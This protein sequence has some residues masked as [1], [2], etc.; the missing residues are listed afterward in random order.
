MG[1]TCLLKAE[2]AQ[3]EIPHLEFVI[4]SERNR[5]IDS[6]YQHLATASENIEQ[7]AQMLG[8]SPEERTKLLAAVEGLRALL[9]V[10]EPFELIVLDPSG[11][12]EFNPADGVRT[13]EL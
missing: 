3:V 6:L 10:E 1:D 9:D 12:S 2:D 11:M 4:C 13:G 7:H 5:R 8:D